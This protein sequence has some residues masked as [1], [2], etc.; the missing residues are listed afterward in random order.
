MSSEA[1]PSVTVLIPALRDSPGLR[2]V[3]AIAREQADTEQGEVLLVLNQAPERLSEES[4][5]ELSR[6][7]DRIAF[8][9]SPGKSA[10]LNRGIGLARGE[11]VAFT[12]DDTLPRSGWLAAAKRRLLAVDRDP[13]LVAF[14]GRVVPIFTVD[15]PE[16]LQRLVLSRDTHYIGPRHDLG[17][18]SVDY[19]IGRSPIGGVWV[20]ANIAVRREVFETFRFSPLLGPS[21]VTGLRGGE[22]T[23]FAREL[24]AAG[25]RIVYEP[26]SAVDHPVS[27]ERASYAFVRSAYYTHGRESIV[28]RRHLGIALP[29][30]RLLMRKVIKHSW[31]RAVGGGEPD[32]FTRTLAAL[33]LAELSGRLR[34]SLRPSTRSSRSVSP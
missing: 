27:R 28:L 5:I 22:E 34:E 14:G 20:G 23:A 6:I 33:R 21:P 9:P 19:P 31:R 11:V 13:R 29:S 7:C 32:E 15:T 1:E 8:E 3:L 2:A 30:K 17:S 10:A 24:I 25:L 16:W 12:D 26:E 4:R 18:E